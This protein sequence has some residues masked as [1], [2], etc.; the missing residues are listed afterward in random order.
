[1]IFNLW[2]QYPR[3]KPK[4]SGFY[5]CTIDKANC[6][7]MQ[8]FYSSNSNKW[9]DIRRQKVFDGYN[10]Y[11]VCRAPIQENHVSTDGLCDRTEDVV[12]WKHMPKPKN[13]K[14]K[15]RKVNE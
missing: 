8:L 11:K 4:K 10:V 5:L 6:Y 7:V 13:I 3:R 9:I 1:M 2:R 14:R 12:A 15:R